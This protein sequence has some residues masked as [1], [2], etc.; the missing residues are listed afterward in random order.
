MRS[1]ERGTARIQAALESSR[2]AIVEAVVDADEKLHQ[3]DDLKT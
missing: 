2:A 3:A 1:G